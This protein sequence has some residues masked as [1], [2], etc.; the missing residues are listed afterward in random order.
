[1]LGAK[2]K[3]AGGAD[4]ASDQRYR[5]LFANAANASELEGQLQQSARA[6]ALLGVDAD[7]VGRHA[8]ESPRL[9]RLE[10]R[11]NPQSGS[12]LQRS[13][14]GENGRSVGLRRLF[15][16]DRQIFPS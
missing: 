2:E 15:R 10:Q 14:V 9:R 1:M 6:F 11:H 16:Q 4:I 8:Q 3:N 12:R 5:I 13:F 7:G